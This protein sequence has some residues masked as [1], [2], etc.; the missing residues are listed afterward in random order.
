MRFLKSRAHLD[1]P[2]SKFGGDIEQLPTE[3]VG[4]HS[5]LVS[6]VPIEQKFN[7]QIFDAIVLK[8]A[9]HFRKTNL[10]LRDHR[11]FVVK[12]KPVEPR[13]RCPFDPAFEWEWS[14]LSRPPAG[15][16]AP[17]ARN[18]RSEALRH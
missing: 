1:I 9:S 10:A 12:T 4:F 16:R 18:T 7:L 8:N 6:P 5:L 3:F 13:A 11:V 14:G 15:K 2:H 17:K